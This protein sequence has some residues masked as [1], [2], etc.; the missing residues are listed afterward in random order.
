MRSQNQVKNINLEIYYFR[1]T[2]FL[3]VTVG[4]VRAGVRRFFG[5]SWSRNRWR[6]RSPV[7]P[8]ELAFWVVSVPNANPW[9]I[10]GAGYQFPS[11]LGGSVDCRWAS[12]CDWC[13]DAVGYR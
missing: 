4:G 8:I 3:E 1:R 10:V 11:W 9:S 7:V 5:C 2:G 12:G 6:Y 13:E